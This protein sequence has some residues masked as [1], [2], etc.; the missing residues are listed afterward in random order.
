VLADVTER[1]RGEQQLRLT[2]GELNHRVK[3]TLATVQ[4]LAQQTL[5]PEAGGT[6]A[7]P[8]NARKAFEG[9]LLALARSHDV[10]TREAWTGAELGE[11]VSLALAPH[12]AS[13]G[14]PRHIAHGPPLRVPPH[15]AVPLGVALHE[16]ATNAARHGALKLPSGRVE[17]SWRVEMPQAEGDTPKLKLRW[18]ESGGP[19][20]T[21]QPALR[22]FGSRFLERGLARELGGAVRL[23]FRPTGV[24]CEI[25]APLRLAG[26][27]AAATTAAA[28]Q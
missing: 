24:V 18:A 21:G 16:L 10:L 5:R 8:T 19:P 15:F 11:L 14:T 26:V 4:S 2:V 27:T 7:I 25:E 12:V 9:R 23:G 20:L 6:G 13:G 28:A 1:R 22:G 3:N 17:V